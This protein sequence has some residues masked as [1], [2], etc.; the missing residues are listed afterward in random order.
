MKIAISGGTGFIGKYLSTFL[1]KKDIMS[2]FLLEKELLKLQPRICN[3][4]TGHQIYLP[5]P[6]PQSI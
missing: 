4:Y 5:S 1:S 2:T 3:T 6:S